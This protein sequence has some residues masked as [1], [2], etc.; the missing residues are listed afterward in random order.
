MIRQLSR[1]ASGSRGFVLCHD[2]DMRLLL[3]LI[4][5]IACQ[6]QSVTWIG[7]PLEPP[8][9]TGVTK[10]IRIS[11]VGNA[12]V[13]EQLQDATGMPTRFTTR[14]AVLITNFDFC[15]DSSQDLIVA[16]AVQV[17]QRDGMQTIVNYLLGS[18]LVK[19]STPTCRT[20]IRFTEPIAS[21]NGLP[22][23]VSA[24]VSD[25]PVAPSALRASND[26]DEVATFYQSNGEHLFN[27]CLGKGRT[28]QEC[29]VETAQF[30]NLLSRKWLGLLR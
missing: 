13:V 26:L 22:V 15:V 5:A 20:A 27:L 28:S 6:A 18:G 19:I 2:T 4:L 3:P 1:A 23:R 14:D 12:T 7:I 8:G 10:L 24:L 17:F 25:L 29:V 30:A 21:L 16:S 9:S 11:R